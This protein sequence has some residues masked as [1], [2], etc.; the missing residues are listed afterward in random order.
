MNKQRLIYIV[1]IL[2]LAQLAVT[3]SRQLQ[4]GSSDLNSLVSQAQSLLAQAR[5][6][7]K[8]AAKTTTSS[9]D[10]SSSRAKN[11]N[12][13]SSAPAKSRDPFVPFFS[14]RN[15]DR[16]GNAVALTD[17]GLSE[18]RV[19]AIISD[20]SGNRSASVETSD[21]KSFIVKV[22]SLIGDNGGEIKEISQGKLVISE[23]AS[24]FPDDTKIEAPSTGSE[25]TVTKE[26]LL[27]TN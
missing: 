24:L 11:T 20:S 6:I 10:P 23:P 5:S 27:K 26:L 9:I 12:S 22:G 2:C 19:A 14:L 21:G 18:M 16:G 17:Y 3:A 4:D 7:G 25:T 1:A 8:D 15:R 13:L